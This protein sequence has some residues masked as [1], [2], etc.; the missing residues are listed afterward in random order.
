MK[1]RAALL[2]WGQALL[3]PRQITSLH[4]LERALGA[5]FARELAHLNQALYA[6]GQS[7]WS[8]F[9]LWQCCQTI[10][11]ELGVCSGQENPALAPFNP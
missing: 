8:G 1:A 6:L 5:D 2:A 10:E 9:E 4:Q 7:G 3:M 11:A